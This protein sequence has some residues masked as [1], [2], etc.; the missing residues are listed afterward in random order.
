MSALLIRFSK[1]C[2]VVTFVLAL[3]ALGFG[4]RS[5]ALTLDADLEAYLLSGGAA[6]GL[7]GDVDDPAS[8]P[9]K[10]CTAC[11]LI[12]STDLVAPMATLPVA[13]R[14]V[15][16]TQMLALAQMRH[17]AAPLDPAKQTRAPPSRLI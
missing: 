4:H 1:L 14:L 16:V 12:A 3:L 10:E 6:S 2:L 13:I 7:C 11:R 9:A 17:H 8:G 5:G 15:Q